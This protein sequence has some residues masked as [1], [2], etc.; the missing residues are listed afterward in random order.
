MDALLKDQGIIV[1]RQ[2]L[3]DSMMR[4]DQEGRE[5]RRMRRVQHV[6]YNV[7]GP[8]HLWHVDGTHN[9]RTWN[10]SIQGCIDGG[11]RLVMLLRCN[12]SNTVAVKLHNFKNACQEY[13]V[14]SRLRTDKGGENVQVAVYMLRMR[15]LGRR[16]SVMGRR[17]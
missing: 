13:M 9:L 10:L 16:K 2:R 3:R 17:R 12:D 11:T 1:S 7:T 14:P 15:G 4:V 8:H 6:E 5:R